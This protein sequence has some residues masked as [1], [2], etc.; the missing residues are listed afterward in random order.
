NETKIFSDPDILSKA[1][2][3]RSFGFVR[4]WVETVIMGEK[5]LCLD[6]I[7]RMGVNVR[8]KTPSK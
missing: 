2:G 1:T 7:I 5:F 8:E 4:E 3:D 6:K